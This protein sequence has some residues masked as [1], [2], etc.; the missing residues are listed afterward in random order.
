MSNEQTL[1]ETCGGSGNLPDSP[2][3]RL[4]RQEGETLPVLTCPDCV[5]DVQTR[6]VRDYSQPCA[7]GFKQVHAITGRDGDSN[8]WCPGGRVI[9]IDYEAGQRSYDEIDWVNQSSDPLFDDW[10]NQSPDPLFVARTVID[11]ALGVR[12]E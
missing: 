3:V 2:L 1:C 4:A 9:V 7:H 12:D 6:I 8:W 11:A 10:H 5:S